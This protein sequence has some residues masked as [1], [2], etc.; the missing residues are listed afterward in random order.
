MFHIRKAPDSDLAAQRTI[1]VVLA[2][3]DFPP[4]PPQTNVDTLHQNRSRI[5]PQF[6]HFGG[7]YPAIPHYTTNSI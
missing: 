4:S 3:R 7:T 1:T 2:L 6:L 5:L